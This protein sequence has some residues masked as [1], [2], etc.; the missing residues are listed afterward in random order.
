MD[1]AKPTDIEFEIV[2]GR[3]VDHEK[4]V[5]RYPNGDLLLAVSIPDVGADDVPPV[6]AN[7]IVATSAAEV[8]GYDLLNGREQPLDFARAGEMLEMDRL[9]IR[10]YPT[11][12]RVTKPAQT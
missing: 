5:F 10:D 6:E 11:L 9:L 12:I 4:H 2:A 1:G 8:T 3:D 7:L